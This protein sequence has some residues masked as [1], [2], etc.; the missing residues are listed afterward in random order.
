MNLIIHSDTWGFYDFTQ[1]D[2]WGRDSGELSV[3][4]AAVID[5]NSD[6]SS[7]PAESNAHNLR[8]EMGLK[9]HREAQEE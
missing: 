1:E 7:A 3:P 8:V 2:R 9:I 6:Q 4:C 5:N